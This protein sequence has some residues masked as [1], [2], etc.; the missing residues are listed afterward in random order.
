[1]KKFACFESRAGFTLIELLVVIT[2]ISV[3]TG[4][5]F[6]GAKIAIQAA[7][8]LDARTSVTELRNGLQNYLAEYGQ[9]PSRANHADTE[10]STSLGS[11]VL[12]ALLGQPTPGLPTKRAVFNTFKLATNGKN[13]LISEGE[14][15]GLVDPWG[16][17]YVILMDTDGDEWLR[18]PDTANTKYGSTAPA[19]VPTRVLVYSK[20]M[21]Q[22]AQTADDL[23]SW[24]N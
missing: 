24:R 19:R 11:E 9:M 22:K 1:M 2:I 23:V 4:L 3:L 6:V 15:Y 10:V 14:T 8:N 20:G 21:D 13:G 7:H 17:P 12:A 5:S 16:E 18:N